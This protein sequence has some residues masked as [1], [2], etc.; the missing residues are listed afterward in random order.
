MVAT[1]TTTTT[2]TTTNTRTGSR[3]NVGT[4]TNK[5]TVGN[6]VTD[7]SIQPYIANRIVSVVGTNLRP[8]NRIHIFFDS[9]NVDQYCRPGV[10]PLSGSQIVI[11]D[12]SDY[13]SIDANG[14]WGDAIRTDASGRVAFQF[15]IP[16]NTFRTGERMLQ[17]ADVDS[18]A[19][20]NTAYTTIAS[21][22][23]TASNLNVTKQNVTLT[24]V[25]PQL[26]F[27]P[28]ACT[29]VTTNTSSQI[30]VIPD[31]INVTFDAQEPIAQALT[32]NTRNGEAG[33]FAT[34]LDL[35]FKQVSQTTNNG[36]TVYLC[37]MDNG[38]PNGNVVLPF[39]R[40]H[41]N[42][43]EVAP[44]VSNNGSVAC[45][46]TFESP[47]FL[48]NGRQYAFVVKPDANDPDYHVFSANLGD[49]DLITGRQ[50]SSQPLTGTAYFGATE[51]TWTALQTEFIK[52][53]LNRANFS[54]NTGSATFVNSNT[55]YLSVYNIGYANSSYSILSGDR[56]FESVNAVVSSAN[57][58]RTGIVQS[59]DRVK[60]ILYV[61]NSTGNFAPNTYV[62]IH[63]F[64]NSSVS[65]SPNNT[66]LIAYANT[67][68]HYDPV[69]DAI[70][71]QL[72]TIA[73]AGTRITYNYQGT[74]NSARSYARDAASGL[75]TEITPGIEKELYDKE[76][77]V[78][79]KSNEVAS[80][81]SAKSFI[82]NA[83]FST[84]TEYLSP[85]I[86][87]VR[88]SQLV[89]KND[90]DPV[91]FE[92][93]EYYNSGVTKS[94]YISQI[95][96]LAEG[97]DAEDLQLIISAYR[98]PG[99]D[100]KVYVKYRNGE[101]PE[102]ISA[103]IWTPMVNSGQGVYCNPSNPNDFREFN[104]ILP[105]LFLPITYANGNITASNASATITGSGTKF[106]QDLR[107]GW[108][109]NFKASQQPLLNNT[110]RAFYA[111]TSGFSNSATVPS[112][113]RITFSNTS[114][115]V[116]GANVFYLVPSGNTALTP[117]T[118]NSYYQI[119]TVNSTAVT[120]KAVGGAAI[121]ITDTRQLGAEET[122]YLMPQELRLLNERT[123]KIV[124]IN[125]NTSLTLDQ[126]FIG[127]YSNL[128]MFLV[129][130]PSCAFMSSNSSV[131]LG[132]TVTTYTSNGTVVGSGTSFAEQVLPGQLINI[133]GDSQ[134]VVS[135][136]NN[137]VMN[138][139]RPW[140]TAVS[141]ANAYLVEKSGLT[142]LSDSN[143][144]YYSFK[145]FQ[146][147][148]ILQSNDSSKVPILDDLRTL[149]LQ[150]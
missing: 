95:V 4:S 49:I 37:E 137:S 129:P 89:I 54:Y 33:I 2:T 135:V 81:G 72:A 55:D 150:M 115:F 8:N 138:F 113:G 139:G 78:A 77:V 21:A 65:L 140:P 26:S 100:I 122:H 56:V 63:R 30:N 131:L 80:M 125:S 67:G 44:F 127:N 23:F 79:S 47:V 25:N 111:N 57:T 11:E 64:S 114:G 70:V 104:F 39:S 31:I 7:V 76:R 105:D 96:T 18:L 59:Y 84:D 32:I 5:Q 126:P 62:Q 145:Q 86:D 147:K 3:L 136:S 134:T 17:V 19:L 10:L 29:V 92:Y 71:P 35:Y 142:Y 83:N 91:Q 94:K 60:G 120:L 66:T 132:G 9:V 88:N 51:T 123:R 50:V 110:P 42:K 61:A 48:S 117:L 36:V 128:P 93:D 41:K 108:Y 98:P 141:G 99:T 22:T 58:S 45:R 130:P 6:F 119:N 27:S 144:N 73:P 46:F 20:G 1:L 90:I 38:Y 106:Q 82:L 40:V 52:F 143:N 53:N 146:I 12:T 124:S 133:N 112:Y 15:N 101:D 34:S 109:L 14:N 87:T 69:V 68:S 13:Q 121:A 43:N 103:K 24:T 85:V 28:L 118:G 75:S 116:A 149:A 107:V 16:E 148:I 97:Q 102:P 74:A